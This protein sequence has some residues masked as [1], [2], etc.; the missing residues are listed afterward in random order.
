MNLV[1]RTKS[2]LTAR[3]LTQL[4]QWERPLTGQ[5]GAPKLLRDI[6]V[7]ADFHWKEVVKHPQG[8]FTNC[9]SLGKYIHHCSRGEN[10]RVLILTTDDSAR[11]GQRTDI[12]GHDVFIV[13][14]LR[15]KKVATNDAAGAYFAGLTG[16][17]IIDLDHLDQRTLTPNAIASLLDK[18][19]SIQEV[20]AWVKRNPSAGADL[21]SSVVSAASAQRVDAREVIRLLKEK[22]SSLSS[23]QRAYILDFFKADDFP[24]NL[25]NAANAA[26]R[27]KA[28][29]EYAAELNAGN[30]DEKKWQT[31]F[32]REEWIFGHGLLYHFLD[33]VVKETLVG[34]KGMSNKGGQVADFSVRTI[35][36]Q[37]SYIALVDIKVPAAKLVLIEPCRNG[38]HAI[39]RDLAE[40][41]A[42]IQGN[43]DVWNR[44]GSKDEKNVRRSAAE[45]WQT[46][47]PRGILV[48]GQTSSLTSL[49]MRQSF[50]LFRR[51]LHGVEILTFDEL[52][53]RAKAIAGATEVGQ[54]VS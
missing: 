23:D 25:V 9:K 41:V 50:E 22:W 34:G 39:H 37:A 47:Q 2:V 6:R 19:L 5:R 11:E 17:P 20:V 44:D 10:S 46:A 42:Q 49:E 32:R 3:E 15:Y 52:L 54:N 43:C 26:Q 28:A 4:L 53:V 8:T 40:S 30:W 33:V 45:G 36:H 12:A 16:A 38:A 1:A 7:Y 51:Q 48:I 27:Q 29:E 21:A 31:F 18:F 35:G 13:N 14:L 24:V